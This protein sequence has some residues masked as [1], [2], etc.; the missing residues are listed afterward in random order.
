MKNT[1]ETVQ[2]REP[3]K[4]LLISLFVLFLILLSSI[5]FLIVNGQKAEINTTPVQNIFADVNGDGAVDLIVAGDII[6]N[7]QQTNF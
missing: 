6:I 3:S 4:L 5:G 2:S 1:S 7:S